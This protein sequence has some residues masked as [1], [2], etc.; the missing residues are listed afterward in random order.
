MPPHG[1]FGLGVDRM[2]MQLLDLPI[3]EVVMFPR[4]RHRLTP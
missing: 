2:M 4:D 3:K 1:G